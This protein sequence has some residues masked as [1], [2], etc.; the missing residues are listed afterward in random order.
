MLTDQSRSHLIFDSTQPI[1]RNPSVTINGVSCA[2]HPSS[3]L[4][5]GKN[6]S[7]SNQGIFAQSQSATRTSTTAST[8]KTTT[9]ATTAGATGITSV[10]KVIC[11]LEASFGRKNL[12]EQQEQQHLEQ[13][14]H[15]SSPI[16][17]GVNNKVTINAPSSRTTTTILPF[18]LNSNNSSHLRNNT[19]VKQPLLLAT[20]SSSSQDK[21]PNS[22]VK[23]QTEREAPES[24]TPSPEAKR[25]VLEPNSIFKTR[26]SMVPLKTAMESDSSCHHH[27]DHDHQQFIHQNKHHHRRGQH[28]HQHPVKSSLVPP[29]TTV[30][31]STCPSCGSENVS[32]ESMPSSAAT[33]RSLS[34]QHLIQDKHHREV[35]T[36]SS[37][38]CHGQ[39][40]HHHPSTS[41]KL[42]QKKILTST[43]LVSAMNHQN[44]HHHKSCHINESGGIINR[45]KSFSYNLLMPQEESTSSSCLTCKGC[46]CDFVPSL[47]KPRIL[48][49]QHILPSSNRKKVTPNTTDPG[50]SSYFDRNGK[51]LRRKKTT[52]VTTSSSRKVQDAKLFDDQKH[53][54]RPSYLSLYPDQNLHLYKH[55]H[56]SRSYLLPPPPPSSSKLPSFLPMMPPVSGYC[57]CPECEKSL[58]YDP[59]E[60]FLRRNSNHFLNQ[61]HHHPHRHHNVIDRS[62]SFHVTTGN[63]DLDSKLNNY[64]FW[65]IDEWRAQVRRQKVKRK[66][67]R[68]LLTVCVVG[69]IVFI[70]VSYF[71]TLLFLRITKF[72]TTSSLHSDPRM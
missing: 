48:S 26:A 18:S 69:I 25:L 34:F 60:K 63:P 30:S 50:Y 44:V 1:N 49:N 39:H 29:L 66:E 10:K 35:T 62:R 14:T 28:H 3:F 9:T 4:E 71:G 15:L 46:D 2:P 22:S 41:S 38:D 51:K 31:V 27:H 64:R 52:R 19:S 56:P 16:H 47:P 55:H 54:Q 33:K 36:T 58:K 72:P 59:L 42:F 21:S 12:S 67:R 70:A 45:S 65:D 23:T 20:T 43:P 6:N 24:L 37:G 5:S 13:R 32:S 11:E 53:R 57:P 40:H 7:S 61:P 17:Q 8:T 68:T